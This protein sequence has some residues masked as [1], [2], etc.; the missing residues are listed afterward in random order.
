MWSHVVLR[1]LVVSN[2][3]AFQNLTTRNDASRRAGVPLSRKPAVIVVGAAVV[4]AG[5]F[6]ALWMTAALATVQTMSGARSPQHLQTALL[7]QPAAAPS[8][9]F[10]QERV[11]ASLRQEEAR[12]QARLLIARAVAATDDPLLAV[13]PAAMTLAGI[14]KSERVA[15]ARSSALFDDNSRAILNQALAASVKE[16]ETLLALNAAETARKTA[17]AG[18][19]PGMVASIA[20][21]AAS[22]SAV[23]PMKTASLPQTGMA[24]AYAAPQSARDV[25]PSAPF[26]EVLAEKE[27][28]ADHLDDGPLPIGRPSMP[29]IAA[30]PA[31]NKPADKPAEKAVAYA[32]P[33]KPLVDEDSG[34]SLF[35]K[36]KSALPGRGSRVAVY[37]ISAGVVYMP[38]GE[39]L[40]A[41]SGRGA[42]RDNPRYV[43]EKNRGPTPPH[44]Y[45]LSMREQRFHGVEAIRMLPYNGKNKFGRDGFLTHTYLLR[46]R[47]D[48]SGCVV[49]ADYPRFLAAFKRG[50][51]KKMIVVP[52][53]A[54][55][56][57]YMAAL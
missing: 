40:E 32:A 21:T 27:D 2:S 12:E 24:L 26:T 45:N 48:S 47:G 22:G 50:D 1:C 29:S 20:P 43:K 13:V 34:W 37:D 11:G 28:T 25:V 4:G 30:K 49:F 3:M 10:K 9:P 57:R 23:D 7:S 19:A 35:G 52:S 15:F 33:E 5:V 17:A 16:R 46:V 54:E 8:R 39:R 41:H 18:I 44:I 38:S 56:P 51:V 42:M 36:K 31:P 55:L 6:A 14:D 53:M